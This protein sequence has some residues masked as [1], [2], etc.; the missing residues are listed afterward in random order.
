[1]PGK[2]L[3]YSGQVTDLAQRTRVF[4]A[5]SDPTRLQIVESLAHGEELTGKDV[6]EK[7]GITLALCCHHTGILQAAGLLNK[8]KRGQSCYHSLNREVLRACL[9]SLSPCSTPV[10]T[11]TSVC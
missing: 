7:L 3:K 9:E 6:S 10:P 5:L 2:A 4:N 1:M 11:P 8:R